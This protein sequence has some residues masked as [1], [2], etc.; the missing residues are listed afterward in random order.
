ML[1]KIIK[2]II[3]LETLPEDS[4]YKEWEI[5]GSRGQSPRK[6]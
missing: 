2:E 4:N 5:W 6:G 3:N 1:H